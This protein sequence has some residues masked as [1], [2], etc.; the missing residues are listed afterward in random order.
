MQMSQMRKENKIND[1][2]VLMILIHTPSLEKFVK[3]VTIG[4]T[5]GATFPAKVGTTTSNAL[6]DTGAT[7]SVMNEKCYPA[8]H[9]TSHEALVQC[10]SKISIRT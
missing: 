1:S 9:A 5:N 2:Q 7:R 4:N 8:L 3:N 10:L 6:T